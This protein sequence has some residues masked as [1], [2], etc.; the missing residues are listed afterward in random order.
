M[1]TREEEQTIA[2]MVALLGKIPNARR[3]AIA[4]AV[5]QRVSASQPNPVRDAETVPVQARV[6]PPKPPRK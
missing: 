4:S 5:L 3:A 1:F 2:A 6:A